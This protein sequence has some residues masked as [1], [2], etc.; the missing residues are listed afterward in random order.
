[1]RTEAANNRHGWRILLVA[2]VLVGLF[3]MLVLRLV[4]LQVGASQHGAD[5]L[6]RQ[7]DLRAVRAAEIPA[8]RGQ[9]TD[10]R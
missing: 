5:F 1:M 3:G 9:I 7:G 10:R 8:F 6:K 4:Q 2:A